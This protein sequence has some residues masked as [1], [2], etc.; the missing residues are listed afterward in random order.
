MLSADVIDHRTIQSSAKLDSG[1]ASVDPAN[2]TLKSFKTVD[3]DDNECAS[4]EGD[5]GR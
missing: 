4:T 5:A 1:P 3:L 2:P